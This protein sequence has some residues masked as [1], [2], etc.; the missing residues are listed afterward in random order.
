M[1][2]FNFVFAVLGATLL[3][4]CGTYIDAAG[5]SHAGKGMDAT[6]VWGET[7]KEKFQGCSEVELLFKQDWTFTCRFLKENETNWQEFGMGY[8]YYHDKH[9]SIGDRSGGGYSGPMLKFFDIGRDEE[10]LAESIYFVRHVFNYTWRSD[11]IGV[12][13]NY[14]MS[15]IVNEDGSQTQ[16][17]LS[18]DSFVRQD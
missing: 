16:L 10:N 6:F 1:K 13:P 18:W 5:H 12:V 9:Y 8:E 15:F 11:R 2:K 3:S 17:E 14:Y 7:N 4:G